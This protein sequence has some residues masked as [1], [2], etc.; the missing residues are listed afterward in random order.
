MKASEIL[1]ST[2]GGMLPSFVQR[3]IMTKVVKDN[4]YTGIYNVKYNRSDKRCMTEEEKKIFRKWYRCIVTSQCT[5]GVHVLDVGCGNGMPFTKYLSD[6]LACDV[7]GIDISHEQVIRARSTVPEV[8]FKCA[9]I[10]DFKSKRAFDGITA[11]YSTFN[12]PRRYHK[13][14]LRKFW[15]LLRTGG[16][17]LINVRKNGVGNFGYTKDWCGSPMIFSYYDAD[18]FIDLAAK[19]GF[20]VYEFDITNNPE[21]KWLMLAKLKTL[22]DIRLYLNLLEDSEKDFTVKV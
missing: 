5:K 1:I 21:Y 6:D 11:M 14:M 13:R 12:I 18:K 15:R 9:D 3:K 7:L 16:S 19:V 2:I 8:R 20:T 17:V 10:L 22:N 4:Y